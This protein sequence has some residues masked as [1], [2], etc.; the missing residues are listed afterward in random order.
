M[1]NEV[2]KSDSEFVAESEDI[3]VYLK[4]WQFFLSYIEMKKVVIGK[5]SKFALTTEYWKRLASLAA[6]RVSKSWYIVDKDGCYMT[7]HDHHCMNLNC[8]NAAILL[9]RR[10][11][12]EPQASSPYQYGCLP[13]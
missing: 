8:T 5:K 6:L 13:N 2:R 1:Y 4:M 10:Q 9:S 11:E 12:A 7:K 3:F